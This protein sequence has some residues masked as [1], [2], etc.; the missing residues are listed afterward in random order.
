MLI[1][2][3]IWGLT[4]PPPPLWDRQGGGLWVS[5]QTINMINMINTSPVLATFFQKNT[6]N[7]I[8]MI[9]CFSH[10]FLKSTVTLGKC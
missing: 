10:F 4:Q 5:H 3:I 1:I 7:M 2:L 8:N 6:I 9:N